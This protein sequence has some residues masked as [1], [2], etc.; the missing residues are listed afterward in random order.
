MKRLL[1]VGRKAAPHAEG[2]GA[3]LPGPAGRKARRRAGAIAL[4]L[5]LGSGLVA[6]T[7]MAGAEGAATGAPG[8]AA[9]A[10]ARIV[11]SAPVI[12]AKVSC[13]SLVQDGF[14]RNRNVADFLDTP[15]APTRVTSAKVVPATGEQPEYCL[16]KGYVQPTVE[17]ELKL[18][19]STWQGR[20][21]QFGCGGVCGSISATTFPACRADLGGDFAIAATND[22]HNAGATDAMWAGISEQNR[23]DFGYRGVH[24]V[25]LAAKAIQSAYYGK[26]PKQSYF[27]GCSD[28]GREALMEAQRYPKD[29]NGIVAGAPANWQS[30]NHFFMGWG[31]R[32][33]FDDRGNPILTA[34]KV[35]PLHDAVVAA[36]DAN[37]TVT[38]DGL[39]GD[40]RDCDFKPS[41]IKCEGPD[42]PDCLTSAQVRAAEALYAG[43]R[44]KHGKRLDPR[45]SPV[46]SEL[47]WP[48]FWMPTP[49]SATAPPG[50]VPNLGIA[51]WMETVPRWMVYPLGKGKPFDEV[52]FTVN[53]FKQSVDKTSKYYDAINPDLRKFRDAGGKLLIYQGW[54]DGLLPPSTTLD[55]YDEMR[56]T[57]GGQAKTD[58]FARLFLV[59]GMGH[60]PSPTYPSPDPSSLALQMVQWVEEGKAPESIV[61]SDLKDQ[62]QRPVFR[63]PLVPRYVGPDPAVDPT[64]PDKLENFVAAQP[65]QRHSDD[66]HWVGDYLY[67]RA[68]F[69]KS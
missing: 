35:K 29:F 16:V 25:A 59:N 9:P 68:P 36:C 64:G 65:R 13:A 38:G 39:I 43:P 11:A 28:G 23:I 3:N 46:G 56:K 32:T 17:F 6:T 52:E 24:V 47:T 48:G 62:R 30:G 20:Y 45:F 51:N 33:N 53:E 69:G 63:Y 2:R 57:M 44:D 21:L 5:A 60:C 40:P 54:A 41:S 26:A 7:Q 66:V 1:K 27:V 15:G 67:N 14:T 50:T 4:A 61:A 34:E 22:G 31:L 19:T 18:P 58:R 55:Y 42:R 8:S 37:D 49:P 10:A 12:P